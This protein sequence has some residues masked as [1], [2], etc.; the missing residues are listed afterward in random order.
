MVSNG[1][2][3]VPWM[4]GGGSAKHSANVG[5]LVAYAATGGQS[6][7]IAPGDFKVSASA[8]TPDGKVHMAV[9]AA[10]IVN[11]SSNAQSESYMTRGLLVSD[12]DVSPTVGSARSD[13]VV[14][15]IKDPQYGW[16]APADLV[17]G[18]Y[19]FPEIIP[20]V[21]AGTV[22][23]EQ[24]NL[25]QAFYA[26][27]R[28]DIPPNT[29]AITNSMIVDLRKLAQPH[30][31]PF[32]DLQVGPTPGENMLTTDTVWKNWPSNVS[33]VEVPV[34]ATHADISIE[35]LN[36]GVDGPVNVDTRVQL[37]GLYGPTYFIDYNGADPT[38]ANYAVETLQ[39]STYASLDVSSLAGQTVNLRLNAMRTFITEAPGRILVDSSSQIRFRVEFFER[40]L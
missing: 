21:A 20:G 8:P 40:P 6:G 38:Y 3:G 10:G 1:L 28:I 15:R 22:R 23:A 31:L 25:Q 11:R 14:I 24:L 27:A 5:R 18:P 19:G 7:V 37:G 29:S 12:L 16:A 32:N 33:S 2:E 34:W 36:L 17:N 39:H 30:F 26:L 35:L 13:L 4:I 9:G